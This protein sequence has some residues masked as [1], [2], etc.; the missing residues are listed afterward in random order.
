[1]RSRRGFQRASRLVLPVLAA[2]VSVASAQF[3]RELG[4]TLKKNLP[5]TGQKVLDDAINTMSE[6]GAVAVLAG[7]AVNYNAQLEGSYG[8]SAHGT[9]ASAELQLVNLGWG[10]GST[11]PTS[12]VGVMTLDRTGTVTRFRLTVGEAFGVSVFNPDRTIVCDTADSNELV[13]GDFS[14]SSDGSGTLTLSKNNSAGGDVVHDLTFDLAVVEGGNH[15]FLSLSTH[16]YGVTSTGGPS[17]IG[18]VL[19]SATGEMR[20][21]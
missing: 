15:A 21:R 11:L 2:F 13:C 3:D 17:F 9:V 19:E 14:V 8:F 7:T 20:R 16:R 1:M 5:P 4:I 6:R 12:Y 10:Q 18:P